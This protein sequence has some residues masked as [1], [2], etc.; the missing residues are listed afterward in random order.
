VIAW[1]RT[2]KQQ[3]AWVGALLVAPLLLSWMLLPKLDY[4]PPVKR[5]AIDAYFSFPP[6]MSPE[7]VNREIVP[8]LLKRMEPY[9]KGEKE[10]RLKNWY[11]L[12]WPSGGTIGARVIDDKRIGDLERVVRDEV[13]AGLPD[14][15]VFVN[16][17]ELFGGIGGSARSVAIHLQS[18]DTD[19]LNATAEEGRKLLER[20]FPGANVQSFPNAD[21][22]ALELR[23]EPN[24][25]RIAEV[26][27]D[28]A[29]LG[30]VVRALGD[31]AWLGEYFDGQTR[32]PVMLRTNLGETP[33][34]LAQAPLMTPSGEIVSLGEL[35]NLQ[36]TLAPE[37]IRRIDHHRTVTLTIDP[38]PTLSLEDMLA[39]IQSD[40]VPSLR[41]QLP[42]DAN[43]R[44][45]GSADRLDAI[46]STMGTNFLLALLVLFMLMAAM[47][48]SLRDAAVVVLTVPLALA[49]G[50]L[51]IRALDLVAFQPLDLLTMIGFIMMIGIIV[52]HSILLVDRTRD[53]L[54]HGH[55]LE[56]ALRMALNQRLRAMVASTL[57]GALG[58]LPMVVN[59]GPA[60]T[61]YR[62]L[63]AVNVAGVIVSM[64]FSIV[65]LPSLL[66]LVYERHVPV[67]EVGTVPVGQASA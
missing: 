29:S 11:V 45:A 42:P 25:R 57:T 47:F 44:L 28:R 43:I 15:R 12:L 33:E 65:L 23:A 41:T 6:G 60:S 9:M 54:N 50:V 32:L 61:I 5:A 21:V 26:G 67:E 13:V 19:A 36:T 14:T 53:A 46:V 38:P 35:V 7:A 17:G 22:Q 30:T 34:E 2:R 31:G 40:I 37:Q 64:V 16:E 20:T 48:R 49:G 59:P 27:W 39:K 52:N 66:R 18:T 3:L 63:A 8:T 55:S 56:E 1:T 51:G 10:P 4:L 62:G 24:D 58:A